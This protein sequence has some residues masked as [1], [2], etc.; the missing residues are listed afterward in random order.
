MTKEKDNLQSTSES[1][2]RREFLLCC[3]FDWKWKQPLIFNQAKRRDKLESRTSSLFEFVI[4]LINSVTYWANL[5]KCILLNWNFVI[6]AKFYFVEQKFC[7]CC[8]I[9]QKLNKQQSICFCLIQYLILSAGSLTWDAFIYFHTYT[10]WTWVKGNK[11]FQP[12]FRCSIVPSIC[13]IR[14]YL[15]Q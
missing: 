14:C 5:F 8:K 12:I 7:Y 6:V 2:V 10:I 1:P 4:F 11:P 9:V 3:A 13:I 15:C